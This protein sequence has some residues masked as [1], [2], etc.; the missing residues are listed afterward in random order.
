VGNGNR[1]HS[2]A[3]FETDDTGAARPASVDRHLAGDDPAELALARRD[4]EMITVADH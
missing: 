4:D 1:R 3:S 2:V